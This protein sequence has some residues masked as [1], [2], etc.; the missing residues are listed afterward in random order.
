M[1]SDGHREAELRHWLVDYLVTTIGCNPDEVDPDLSFN[2]LGVGSRDAVVLSGELSELIGWP[3]SPVEFWQHPTI[4]ALAHFLSAPE[5][6]N[7]TPAPTRWNVLG[8]T[9]RSRSSGW[10]AAFPAT[11]TGQKRYGSSYWTAAAQSV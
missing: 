6:P 8:W 4:K 1:T 7:Q 9:S 3:V 10:V 11:L 5:D 2:H